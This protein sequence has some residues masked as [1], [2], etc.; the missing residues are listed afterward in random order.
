[1]R[2][3][4]IASSVPLL[5][6]AALAGCGD[7][8]VPDVAAPPAERT[9]ANGPTWVLRSPAD[10][11]V[12][13][14][15]SR[16][17]FL[18]RPSD[19][20]ADGRRG[21]VAQLGRRWTQRPATAPW[22]ELNL[23]LVS[24]H[25]VNPPRAARGYALVSLAMHDASVAARYWSQRY[26]T[27]RRKLSGYPS[28][29]AAVAGAASRVLAYLFPDHAPAEL[30]QIA[31]QA[32]DAQVASG[33]SSRDAATA[34]LALGRSVGRAVMAHARA[35]GS[36]R[37][38]H[39]RAP[40]AADAWRDPS[41]SPP[42]EPLAGSW[43]TWVLRSGAQ[44]RPPPPPAFGSPEFVA[45]AREVVAFDRRLTYAQKRIAKF[46]EGGEGTP[47]PPGVWNEVALAYVRRDRL[48]TAQTAEVF[49]LMNM[50]MADTAVATWDAKFAYWTPR[51]VTAIRDL[52][53]E[54]RWRPF[55]T[56]PPFPAYVSAHSSF[57]GAASEVLAALFRRDRAAFHATAIEA[58]MS[59]LYGGIH[60]RFDHDAGLTLGRRIG[61]LVLERA[62]TRRG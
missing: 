56:T 21:R 29:G 38:R 50:A 6:V 30:D 18:V 4:A 16:P 2:R 31:E 60:F 40:R 33:A 20:R 36:S 34:G 8:G 23:E 1:M 58:G 45:A 17:P 5:V 27:G 24:H 12:P 51:P 3:L 11:T 54:R 15:A 32:A 14:P 57:S 49:A 59:R 62:T 39:E 42:A 61:R 55:L 10:V 46:W 25:P 13:P 43:R 7:S 44:L 26:S 22:T 53:V 35:D 19:T 47:L 9:L 52:A 48:S 37:R 28:E 41:G